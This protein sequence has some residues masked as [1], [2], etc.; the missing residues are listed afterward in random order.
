M[1]KYVCK[2]S[3]IFSINYRSVDMILTIFETHICLN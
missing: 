2:I 3:D 1:V